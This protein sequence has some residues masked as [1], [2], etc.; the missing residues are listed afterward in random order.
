MLKY[1]IPEFRLP[2]SIVDTEIDA[3]KELGV[4]FVSDVVVGK[5]ITYD[6]LIESGYSGVFVASGVE[7]CLALWAYPERTL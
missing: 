2:N 4:E 5:T 6:N 1:G 3:L 7:A